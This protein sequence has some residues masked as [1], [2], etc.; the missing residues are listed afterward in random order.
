MKLLL[1]LVLGVFLE[2]TEPVTGRYP[3]FSRNILFTNFD[4]KPKK[5]TSACKYKSE[6]YKFF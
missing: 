5:T 6:E 3:K 4:I 1:L 2:E